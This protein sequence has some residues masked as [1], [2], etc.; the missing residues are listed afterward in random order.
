MICGGDKFTGIFGEHPL[1]AEQHSLELHSLYQNMILSDVSIN[2]Q[3]PCSILIAFTRVWNSLP[4]RFPFYCFLVLRENKPWQSLGLR[5][6]A[7][8]N[9][10]VD[11]IKS[12]KGIFEFLTAVIF[13][14]ESWNLKSL[15]CCVI[16]VLYV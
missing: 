5:V 15:K 14:F 6:V 2:I 8:K 11:S 13:H 4:S 9:M 3:F 12:E 1:T 10:N 16:N 7:K